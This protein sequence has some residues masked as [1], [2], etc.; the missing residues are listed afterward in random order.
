[1]TRFGK[2]EGVNRCGTPEGAKARHLATLFAT[3]A[4]AF[5]LS[6]GANGDSNEALFTDA[7]SALERGAL[8]DAIDRLELL[9]DRLSHPDAS[10]DW[11]SR[12]C[13]AHNPKGEARRSRTR[14]GCA[15]GGTEPAGRRGGEHGARRVRRNRERERARRV[16]SGLKPSLSWAVSAC[17]KKIRGPS[18]R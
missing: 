9:A 6:A 5:A 8:D 10:Y 1:V 17:W 18:W 3:S 14:L 15:R 11:Q 4:L 13:G 12:T 7:V 16:R 2:P